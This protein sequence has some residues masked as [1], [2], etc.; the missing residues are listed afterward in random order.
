MKIF[1]FLSLALLSAPV[2]ASQFNDIN[3]CITNSGALLVQGTLNGAGQQSQITLSGTGN[4]E[5]HCET[6]SGQIPAAGNKNNVGA[7]VSASGLFCTTT[8][9]GIPFCLTAG[10]PSPSCESGLHCGQ[11]QHAVTTFTY[12][13]VKLAST[14]GKGKFNVGTVKDKCSA[15]NQQCPIPNACS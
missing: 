13:N 7:P 10:P 9:G 6:K 1:Q 14:G 4:A 8:Q 2:L 11:G 3:A 12:T 15:D 5:C